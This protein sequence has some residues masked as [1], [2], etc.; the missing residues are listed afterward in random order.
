VERLLADHLAVLERMA[1]DPDARHDA[2]DLLPPEERRR[3]LAEWNDAARGYPRDVPVHELF[4]AAARVPDAPAVTFRG[5]TVTYAA[6]AARADA[7]AARLRALGVGPESVVGVCMARTPRLIAA[8]VAVLKS[9]GACLPLDPAYPADRLAFMLADSGAR[10]VVTQESLAGLFA[11]FGGDVMAVDGAVPE[12]PSPPGPL[13]PASG[14]KG[15]HDNG[16]DTSLAPLPLAGEGLGRGPAVSPDSL[17]YL[18]YTS[19][20]TGRPKGVAIP[21]GAAAAFVHWM[22]DTVSDEE[23]AG[24]LASTSVSFD[25]SVAEIWGT[26]CW[27]GR[28]VLVEN[29]LELASLGEADGVRLATM[30]PTAAAELLRTGGIPRSVRAFNLAGEPLPADLARGLYALGHVDTVRNLYGPTEDTT[31]S[32]WTVVERGAE[33]VPIGRAV[34]DSRAYVL[35]AE[36]RPVPV[37][38]AGE[39]YLA[40]AGVARGYHARPGLTAERFLP[41]PFSPASGGR[42]YRTLDRAR[43][44]PAGELEYLGR[45][46][47]QVKLRGFRV[48][49]G[50]VEA[51][52]REHPAVADAAAVIRAD[53]AGE[54][55]MVAYVV[56]A[57]GADAPG[58]AALRGWLRERLPEH[59]VPSALVELERLPLTPS[60]KT[61]RRA[62][63][64]PAPGADQDTYVAPRTPT[65]ERLAAVWA[66]VLRV[67]RVGVADTFFA[68][69]GHSLLATQVVSRVR[70]AF[71]VE[72]LVADLFD[73]PTVEALAR[74]VDGL[75]AAGALADVQGP[76]TRQARKSVARRTSS[77]Q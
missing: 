17:A 23:R 24:V 28:L 58:A 26:L 37:G 39:L 20:S 60:G 50:E 61:D 13:S 43:W 32:T 55:R 53:G 6:L 1:A 3:V 31:Y 57:A 5:R 18:I 10:V 22:R 4:A 59:M 35:D 2:L 47:T 66:E 69:G 64:A 40:G 42:M 77:P 11:G 65:E 8:L 7:L 52:L 30:V 70:E 36:L 72:L 12:A 56:P 16:N 48:E 27:G 29:A 62:L 25:V 74:R 14:R 73:D 76:I 34:G 54:R 45:A 41:D 46:D 67:P 71:R 15:E 19:G 75:L 49:L 44:S 51:V 68:L 63:P 9:G 21:H 38:A 33:R